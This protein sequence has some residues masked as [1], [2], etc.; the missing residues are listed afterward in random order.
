[1]ND[2]A[3]EPFV[4]GDPRFRGTHREPGEPGKLYRSEMYLE[5][6]A[7]MWEDSI[8]L[9]VAGDMSFYHWKGRVPS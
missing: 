3:S 9:A 2:S 8:T 6:L 4:P 1:M 5:L 7:G